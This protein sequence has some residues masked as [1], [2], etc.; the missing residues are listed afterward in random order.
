MAT[1]YV[2]EELYIILM[3]VGKQSLF[4]VIGLRLK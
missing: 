3:D 1:V 4:S 2:V